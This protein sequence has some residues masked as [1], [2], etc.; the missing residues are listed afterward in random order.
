[1]PNI[2][3]LFTILASL[4]C[5]VLPG[6][7]VA[8]I[9]VSV[10][11]SPSRSSVAPGDQFVIAVVLQHQLGWHTQADAEQAKRLGN[12]LDA[13]PT[14]IE[15]SEAKGLQFGPIQWPKAVKVSG[16]AFGDPK[17]TVPV[18]EETAVAY[19]PVVVLPGA[20]LGAASTTIS[21]TYQACNDTACL[22]PETATVEVGLTIAAAGGAASSTPRSADPT[23]FAGFDSTVFTRMLAGK[24]ATSKNFDFN[25]FGSSFTIDTDGAGLVLLLLLAVVG[26]LVLN[27]TP[28]VLPVIPIK[29]MSL[30]HT[31]GTAQRRILLG[32]VMSMGVVAFWVAIG[33]AMAFV[34]GFTAAN[35]LF[36]NPYFTI[37]IGLFV[38]VMG[39]GMLGLFAVRLPNWVYAIDPKQES[40]VG[41]FLFGIMTAVLATPCIAPFGGAA[42][43]WATKQPI[44][45]LLATFVAI[46]LGMSVP[47]LVLALFPRL[48]ARVPKTG[49]ASELVKQVMGILMLAVAVF[50]I[51]TGIDPLVRLPVD[52]PIRW[53]WWVVGGLAIV[54]AAWLVY[55]TW[56][57][58][59][60]PARRAFWTIAGVLFAG[61][62]VWIGTNFSSHGPIDWVGYTPERLAAAEKQGKVVVLDFTAEWCGNCKALE[63]LVLHQKP[64]V[65]LFKS[66]RAIPMRVDLT[67]NNKT[68]AAKLQELNWVGIPLLAIYGPAQ[69]EPLKYDTYTIQTVLDAVAKVKGDT[70]TIGS[71]TGGGGG[72]GGAG[73]SA[74]PK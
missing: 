19:I 26:G 4:V 53:F 20:T 30:Q 28:C 25:L 59:K 67:G 40:V 8:G 63:S 2:K 18:F 46:G 16:A 31:A 23:L 48:V 9:E 37:G 68:G 3:W 51:G 39:V 50:F 36:Q 44:A 12:A 45:V 52:P 15:V 43:A 32:S 14:T 11:A 34:K 64:I 21:V 7:A 22:F 33:L 42:M 5:L 70:S 35:Q 66:G 61:S 6:R 71:A 17:A 56:A 49:P 72:G 57:I 47:Y 38:A 13:K 27:L 73:T 24:I 1:M 10:S 29:I 55:R 69:P 62:G 60:G 58:T 65:E 74:N 41:S 54:A